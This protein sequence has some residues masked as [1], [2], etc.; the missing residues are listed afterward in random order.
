[1]QRSSSSLS[2]GQHASVT[3]S[4]HNARVNGLMPEVGRAPTILAR[5][6]LGGLQSER[7]DVQLLALQELRRMLQAGAL[8]WLRVV[9]FLSAR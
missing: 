4:S 7:P 1:M 3:R 5:D 9:Y 2:P 8:L 6:I